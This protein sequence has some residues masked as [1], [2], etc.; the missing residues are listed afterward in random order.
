MFPFI[1]YLY[2]PYPEE[3]KK[4]VGGLPG[5]VSSAWPVDPQALLSSLK[6]PC[7]AVTPLPV[8]IRNGVQKGPQ[9]V[10]G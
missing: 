4:A 9:K 6:N 10:C 7:P 1:T 3:E 2:S 8:V 5:P